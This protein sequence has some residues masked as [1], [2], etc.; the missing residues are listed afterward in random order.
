MLDLLLLAP[1]RRFLDGRSDVAAAFSGRR[2]R[3]QYRGALMRVRRSS[4]N[5]EAD[6][7]VGQAGVD[8]DAL[9]GFIGGG[10]GYVS[11]WYDQSGNGHDLLQASASAQ[12]QIGLLTNGLPGMT[13]DGLNDMLVTAS[14]AL[15]QPCSFNIVYRRASDIGN[16]FQ[17]IFDGVTGDTGTL[18]GM[19]GHFDNGMYANLP[20]PNLEGDTTTMPIGTRGAVGGTFNGAAALLEVNA[21][22]LASA[23]GDCGANN[24]DGLTLGTRGGGLSS[25]FTN[26]E[27]QEFIAFSSGH[28]AAQVRADNAA[29]RAAW[30]F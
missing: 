28:S 7:G 17:N 19:T 22:R 11:K 9:S 30:R 3:T 14:F 25:R 18:Y 15:S 4:D 2:L 26:M 6:F 16:A 24:M 13:F 12:P 1:K 29:M 21:A 27:A 20:A 23:T 10:S 5:L 8:W